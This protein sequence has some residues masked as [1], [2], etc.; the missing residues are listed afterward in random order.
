MC[1]IFKHKWDQAA[2]DYRRCTV[3]G[4]LQESGFLYWRDWHR[5]IEEWKN[6]VQWENQYFSKK[7][8]DKQ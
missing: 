6:A 4:K 3:C 8:A 1:G 7:K 2:P 5:T